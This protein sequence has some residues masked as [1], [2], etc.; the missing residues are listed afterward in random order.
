MES[1]ADGS[2]S[3]G[4]VQITSTGVLDVH[5]ATDA[6]DYYTYTRTGIESLSLGLH[7]E[8]HYVDRKCT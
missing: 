4:N 2:A 1:V 7:G 3:F 5:P 8:R 6:R